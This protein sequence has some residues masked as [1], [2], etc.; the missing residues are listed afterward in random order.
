MSKSKMS[1]NRKK[2]E[3]R[4][5]SCGYC[6][7]NF[8]T[9]ARLRTHIALEHKDEASKCYLCLELFNK[10]PPWGTVRKH[11]ARFHKNDKLYFK[12]LELHKEAFKNSKDM[13]PDNK[14]M[15][16]PSS[17]GK[18]LKQGT[19]EQENPNSKGNSRK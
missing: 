9:I 18:K 14:D 6:E 13:K 5:K 15:K 1:S 3:N 16:Q 11:Y 8:I 7:E 17:S 19:E 2:A 12:S 4:T 10:F